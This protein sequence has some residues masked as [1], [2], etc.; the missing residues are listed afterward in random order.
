MSCAASCSRCWRV[1]RPAVRAQRDAV[2]PCLQRQ[3]QTGGARTAAD[4]RERLVAVL[5]P[6][7]VR[8]V[9]DA[10]AVALLDAGNRSAA[11]RGCR[12][13]AARPARGTRS[14]SS[15]ATSNRAA[16]RSTAVTVA[17]RMSIPYG[18]SSSRPRRSSSSGGV[19]SRVRNPW[20]ACGRSVAR[21]SRV[22]QQHP[23]A[24]AAEDQGRAQPGG[25]AADDD[26]V[27][28]RRPAV[29]AHGQSQLVALKS[30]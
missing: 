6:V 4:D 20:S 8:T 11:D 26:D 13:R 18:P 28:H 5:P 14:D 21:R 1:E 15:I 29:Q 7:A 10:D 3:R 17:L 16:P 19:P 25:S 30:A 27:V 23:P 2:G 24:A 12:W 9:M 22:A